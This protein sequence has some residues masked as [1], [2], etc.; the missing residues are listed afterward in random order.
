MIGVMRG[1]LILLL[2]LWII[3][4]MLLS[5]CAA[6]ATVDV[7]DEHD[8]VC[9]EKAEVCVDRNSIQCSGNYCAWTARAIGDPRLFPTIADCVRSM[10]TVSGDPAWTTFPK[11]SIAGSICDARSNGI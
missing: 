11:N 6:K 2:A 9:V 1:A 4:G 8:W 10:L 7:P 5:S 3:V